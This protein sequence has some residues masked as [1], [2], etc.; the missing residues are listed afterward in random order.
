MGR[1]LKKMARRPH[2]G[3]DTGTYASP[4]VIPKKNL[5]PIPVSS[6]DTAVSALR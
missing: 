3:I 1:M 6:S 2:V 4:A 5:N